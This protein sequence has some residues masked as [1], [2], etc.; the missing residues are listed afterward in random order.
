MYQS[1]NPSLQDKVFQGLK[2]GA[3]G[4]V[5][6]LEGTSNKTILAIVILFLSGWYTMQHPGIWG[7]TL[8]ALI[9]GLVL[10]LII[11]F[12]PQT[13]PYLTPV[14]AIIEGVVLGSISA[15][16]GMQYEHLVSQA[17]LLTFLTAACMLTGYRAGIIPM[18]NS[19]MATVT[20][21]T[22]AVAIF[23]LITM[24]AGMFGYSSSFMQSSS[25]ISIGFS[26]LVTALAAFNLVVDFYRIEMMA[27]SGQAPKYMEWYG[28]FAILVT[29]VWLY[30]EILKL[31]RKIQSRN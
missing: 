15:Y 2:P 20:T 18:N 11:I 9:A 14:Y 17:V 6:T 31:L 22:A 7:L 8:P 28:A 12:K 5:M 3:T 26:V 13:A 30:L 24:V 19:I 27:K 23:Y 10:S 4:A 16:A 1:S 29:L 21:A 25:P